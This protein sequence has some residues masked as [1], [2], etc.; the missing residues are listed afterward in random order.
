MGLQNYLVSIREA[1]SEAFEATLDCYSWKRV[2]SRDGA[3][4][5]ALQGRIAPETEEWN[6]LV[7]GIDCRNSTWWKYGVEDVGVPFGLR[8]EMTVGFAIEQKTYVAVKK[9][10]LFKRAMAALERHGGLSTEQG[11]DF[12]SA[13]LK[14]D[15]SKYA[16]DT[17]NALR[18]L[19]YLFKRES[20]P[21]DVR[22]FSMS[23]NPRRCQGDGTWEGDLP[24][25]DRN[26]IGPYAYAKAYFDKSEIIA[27]QDEF[28]LNGLGWGPGVL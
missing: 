18:A 21:F 14:I 12:M 13:Q 23:G 27:N 6:S 28:L 5:Y 26:G 11:D 2:A 16:G 10:S 9:M 25:D 7:I 20:K 1:S 4:L 17:C 15:V 24:G 19:A 22:Y 3:H 8:L